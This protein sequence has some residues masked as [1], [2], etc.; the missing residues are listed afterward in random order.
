MTERLCP[1]T[2][3]GDYKIN[4]AIQDVILLHCV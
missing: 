1:I 2:D 3:V 4:S